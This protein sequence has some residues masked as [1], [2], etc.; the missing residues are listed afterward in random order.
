MTSGIADTKP[1]MLIGRVIARLRAEKKVDARDLAEAINIDYS[2]YTRRE[3][4]KTPIRVNELM[5]VA[6]ELRIPAWEI[7]REA[8]TGTPAGTDGG[9]E[10]IARQCFVDAMAIVL[11]HIKRRRLDLSPAEIV[12]AVLAYYDVIMDLE[13]AEKRPEAWP[14]PDRIISLAARRNQ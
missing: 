11:S 4:G 7:V 1:T 8:E 13:L 6:R 12:E 10:P 2:N 14:R 5:A 3:A 9:E